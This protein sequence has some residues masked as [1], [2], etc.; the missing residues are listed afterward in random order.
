MVYHGPGVPEV[1][2]TVHRY[3]RNRKRNPRR[4]PAL[5]L[6][7]ER[8]A[9]HQHGERSIKVQSRSLM[10]SIRKAYTS[11]VGTDEV[12]EHTGP[13]V[14]CQVGWSEAWIGK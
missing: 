7:E 4:T 14:V 3:A 2:P 6:L 12:V 9:T 10:G 11:A 13:A 5:L 8:S 1:F